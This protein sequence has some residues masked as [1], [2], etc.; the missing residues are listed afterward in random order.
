MSTYTAFG[1]L[2]LIVTLGLIELAIDLT[3][4]TL[5]RIH[6]LINR[7]PDILNNVLIRVVNLFLCS[8]YLTK[9]CECNRSKQVKILAGPIVFLCYTALYYF[10]E[11]YLQ[12]CQA[13][14]EQ[15]QPWPM[16]RQLKVLSCIALN[17]E[18]EHC[19]FWKDVFGDFPSFAIRFLTFIIHAT[20]NALLRA[21]FAL[22][23]VPIFQI[24]AGILSAL[25][26]SNSK[27]VLLVLLAIPQVIFWLNYSRLDEEGLDL[28]V[29]YQDNLEKA[30]W[31]AVYW[32]L[33]FLLHN[34]SLKIIVWFLYLTSIYQDFP[35]ATQS[36]RRVLSTGT[37]RIRM[38]IAKFNLN[39]KNAVE[40][41][42][43]DK[44]VEPALHQLKERKQWVVARQKRKRELADEDEAS[45]HAERVKI[46]LAHEDL[47][48]KWVV[49][50]GS[51]C[52]YPI[53]NPKTG[54]E[55]VL[56]KHS[57]PQSKTE[58]QHPKSFVYPPHPE[59]LLGRSVSQLLREST[60]KNPPRRPSRAELW[61]NVPSSTVPC[62]Y[63][64]KCAHR[65][66]ICET[67]LV[68]PR[69]GADFTC[70]SRK[71]SKMGGLSIRKSKETASATPV[72]WCLHCKHCEHR[73]PQCRSC[74]RCSRHRKECVALVPVSPTTYSR[75][76][77]DL[78]KE[79]EVLGK[80]GLR[81]NASDGC[82]TRKPYQAYAEDDSSNI[83]EEMVVERPHTP[84]ES[85]P[86]DR[87]PANSSQKSLHSIDTGYLTQLTSRAQTLAGSPAPPEIRIITPTTISGSNSKKRATSDIAAEENVSSEVFPFPDLGPFPSK[88]ERRRQRATRAVKQGPTGNKLVWIHVGDTGKK[89]SWAWVEKEKNDGDGGSTNMEKNVEK[90]ESEEEEL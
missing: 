2:S 60:P 59:K 55:E 25:C 26:T 18:A 11:Y 57:K 68:C 76:Q 50:G 64:R 5:K 40:K 51:D 45:K 46:R 88:E 86:S 79:E 82:A 75:L 66:T 49:R 81:P 13:N 1:L 10:S 17:P 36:L 53:K 85:P 74:Q 7:V 35:N 44:A 62:S 28:Q 42:G 20:P 29:L 47:Q 27:V 78:S 19:H 43:K 61:R 24:S 63:C 34:T 73:K 32:F 58:H 90:E 56:E 12:Q 37:S 21:T 65:K 38:S 71:A 14:I 4:H 30:K 15:K 69:R 3:K 33:L 72:Y 8:Y 39:S 48:S 6:R 87:S 80:S 67:C 52:A 31:R 70:R 84:L 83:N 23:I 89:P 16:C 22:I 54:I 9:D 77:G 41:A